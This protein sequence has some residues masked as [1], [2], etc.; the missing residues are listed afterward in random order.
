MGDVWIPHSRGRSVRPRS[1]KLAPPGPSSLALQ[2][3]P[4]HVSS[5]GCL[6]VSTLVPLLIR[7]PVRQNQGNPHEFILSES[8]QALELG[9]QYKL[10]APVSFL[11]WQK[12][13]TIHSENK[14]A[15]HP[16]AGSGS[17]CLGLF[18]PQGHSPTCKLWHHSVK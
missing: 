8:S 12:P 7:T 4:F 1:A 14:R 5:K 11:Q 16:E 18:T 10:R 9:H 6:Y 3:C 13:G 15:G 17:T 2:P